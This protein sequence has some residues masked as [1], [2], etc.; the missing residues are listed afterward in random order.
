LKSIEANEGDSILDLAHE[1]DID[2]EGESAPGLFHSL[3]L[4]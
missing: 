2:L 4:T 3:E 1:Y